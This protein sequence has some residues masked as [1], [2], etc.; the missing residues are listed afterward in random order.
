MQVSLQNIQYIS[1]SEDGKRLSTNDGV[2]Q[3]NDPQSMDYPN[4][5]PYKGLCNNYQEGGGGGG[6]KMSFTKGKIR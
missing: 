3:N 6:P 5:L 4:R 2:G 1:Q